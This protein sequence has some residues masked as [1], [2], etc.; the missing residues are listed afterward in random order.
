M[1]EPNFIK[2]DLQPPANSFSIMMGGTSPYNFQSPSYHSSSYL[3]KMEANFWNNLKCCDT[4]FN[5]LHELLSHFEDVHSQQPSTFPYRMSASGSNGFARRKSSTPAGFSN[6]ADRA[7]NQVRGFRPVTDSRLNDLQSPQMS[8]DLGNKGTGLDLQ[9]MNM[10]MD[11]LGDMELDTPEPQMFDQDLRSYA[12]DGDHFS[13][14]SLSSHPPPLRADSNG[15]VEAQGQMSQ[16]SNPATPRP[17]FQGFG[18]NNPMVSSVNTPTFANQQPTD[19]DLSALLQGDLSQDMDSTLNANNFSS[20]TVPFNSQMLQRLNADF[21]PLDFGQNGNDM[22]DLCISEPAKALY[23]ENGG[24]NTQQFP[25]FNFTQNTVV[26]NG[27]EN[28][29]KLQA[30]RLASGMGKQPGDEERP[31]KC[32]VIG[33]E[34]AYKNANGLRYH[35]KVGQMRF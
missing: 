15:S 17:M 21:G 12:E 10:E 7:L 18:Q 29:R 26:S 25:H 30:Y 6:Q 35:E 23:S 33:C 31:F 4:T 2:P 24:F 32:P 19:D 9:H 13:S 1:S 20:N 34:K 28:A 14:P 3:P 27:D 11:T 16:Q 22:L 5:D 8:A